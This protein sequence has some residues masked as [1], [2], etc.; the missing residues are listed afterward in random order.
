VNSRYPAIDLQI[1]DRGLNDNLVIVPVSK[2][3]KSKF[4]IVACAIVSKILVRVEQTRESQ[5]L[6]EEQPN[7]IFTILSAVAR[8]CRVALI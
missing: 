1:F 5:N 6:I 4:A 3:R 8:V 2:N 7:C